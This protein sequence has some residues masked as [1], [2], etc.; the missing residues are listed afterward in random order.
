MRTHILRVSPGVDLLGL[1]FKTSNIEQSN[2]D[3][4]IW[5][6]STT[7]SIQLL[8]CLFWVRIFFTGTEAFEFVRNM[9]LVGP[10]RGNSSQ[11]I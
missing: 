8:K 1:L 6:Q 5:K 11:H 7:C 3:N 2:F 10:K 4:P 9:C